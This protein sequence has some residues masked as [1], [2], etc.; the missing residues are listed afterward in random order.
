MFTETREGFPVLSPALPSLCKVRHLQSVL[1][2]NPVAQGTMSSSLWGLC[3]WPFCLWEPQ[4]FGGLLIWRTPLSLFFALQNSSN[5]FWLGGNSSQGGRLCTS[6]LNFTA[7]VG[8]L[9]QKT[10]HLLGVG[11]GKRR[12]SKHK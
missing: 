5:E 7:S 3:H 8:E 10:G 6:N 11:A 12:G 9:Y 4:T 1:M 2:W